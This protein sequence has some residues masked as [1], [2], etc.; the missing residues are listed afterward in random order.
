MN[1]TQ[2][3]EE[4]PLS[5]NEKM[6]K[7]N[8]DCT[9]SC[10][11]KTSSDHYA[12]D[13]GFAC[14]FFRKASTQL[15]ASGS[16]EQKDPRLYPIASPY[17]CLLTV[18][19][20]LLA[21]SLLMLGDFAIVKSVMTEKEKYFFTW[22]QVLAGFNVLW[23]CLWTFIAVRKGWR[24]GS[25]LGFFQLVIMII[26][27]VITAVM[28]N[29]MYPRAVEAFILPWD[30][31]PLYIFTFYMPGIFYSIVLLAEI[32][33]EMKYVLR[34]IY[35]LLGIPIGLYFLS[36]LLV[37]FASTGIFLPFHNMPQAITMGMFF[38]FF[39]GV[40]A[41]FYWGAVKLMIHVAKAIYTVPT[42]VK[43][44]YFVVGFLLPIFGLLL[45]SAI[46]FPENFQSTAVYLFTLLNAI[47]LFLPFT[48]NKWS[49]GII[50]YLKGVSYPF[51]LYFFL[52]FLPF[53]PLSVPAIIVI[54]SGF[55][56]MAPTL[57]FLVQTYQLKQFSVSFTET[58]PVRRYRVLLILGLLTLPALFVV[59]AFRDRA[60]LDYA[61]ESYF[62][63]P[64]MMD[65]AE[66]QSK[67]KPKKV[68]KTLEKFYLA[69]RGIETP[70]ISMVYNRI[71]F[72]NLVFSD[73]KMTMMYMDLAGKDIN[74]IVFDSAR[75]RVFDIFG[76]NPRG[77]ARDF[78][79][80]TLSG[81]SARTDSRFATLKESSVEAI[82]GGARLKLV[83]TGEA[84]NGRVNQ[85]E[86]VNFFTIPEGMLVSGFTLDIDGEQKPGKI[87]EKKAAF[88]IYEKITNVRRDP[89]LLSYT[90]PNELKLMV[91]PVIAW[92]DRVVTIDLLY[93]ESTSMRIE[94]RGLSLDLP[95]Y[96]GN[97]DTAGVRYFRQ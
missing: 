34:S 68:C 71:V 30:R 81:L 21:M 73:E 50:L 17:W 86:Y 52:V 3:P 46:P 87:S 37:K 18:A 57:L 95:V 51:C 20:P 27:L 65:Y 19:L 80:H 67:I 35:L 13:A 85:G 22:V 55:L 8:P 53:L 47:I 78:R 88:W 42:M 23:S 26:A 6:V 91:F 63:S 39:I 12:G 38:A 59:N 1:D 25:F 77:N 33:D 5:I 28:S 32:F 54:G 90:S 49:D 29:D 84:T 45:N 79:F 93:P 76:S 43:S 56:V 75:G 9:I 61:V 64:Y 83:I 24:N 10:G 66:Q 41:L 11:E 14:N 74:Q 36:L 40:G 48:G 44:L 16:K 97:G 96:D 58:Y 89:A 2:H 94:G 72:G 69:K 62:N 31:W 92:H 7:E 15:A 70:L 82:P 60:D 4:G